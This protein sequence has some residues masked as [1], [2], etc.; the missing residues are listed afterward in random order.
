[1]TKQEFKKQTMEW[2]NNYILKL[3]K[4]I[5]IDAEHIRPLQKQNGEL[6]D[7]VKDYVL[8][9]IGSSEHGLTY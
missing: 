7:K 2:K 3:E 1:M 5:Q 9:V 4:Q 8:K 6:T